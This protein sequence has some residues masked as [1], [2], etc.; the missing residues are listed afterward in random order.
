MCARPGAVRGRIARAMRRSVSLPNTPPG[1][2]SR[3]NAAAEKCAFEGACAVNASA[4]E[5]SRFAGSVE[6]RN[7][8][9]IRCTEDAALQVSL[10][11][12]QALAG[13]DE[14]P[15][16]DQRT[17]FRV[18]DRLEFRGAY[19][20]A[21]IAAEVREAAELVVVEVRRAAGDHVIPRF[22][23]GF[24]FRAVD[25]EA[26]E[27]VGIHPVHKLVE[28]VGHHEVV[29]AI[30]NQAI[31]QALVAEENAGEQGEALFVP[32]GG[33]VIAAGDGQ[34]ADSD[35][36]IHDLPRILARLAE[37]AGDKVAGVSVGRHGA[38]VQDAL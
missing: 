14:L 16:R 28:R 6:S 24:H 15:N 10:D 12:A 31:D 17:G 32:E 3:E 35:L 29:R 13:E 9:T 7:R 36:P 38:G 30:A 37:D 2:A 20:I 5:S 33:H 4:A 19:A 26:V 23:R 34:F 25:L 22:D 27:A 18:E 8:L 21:P 1:Q 11:A